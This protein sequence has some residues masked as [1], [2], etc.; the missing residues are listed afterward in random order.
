MELVPMR[1]TRKGGEE[2]SYALHPLRPGKTKDEP[3]KT[4]NNGNAL[5]VQEGKL[6]FL[7]FS[8][9]LYF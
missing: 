9:Y 5:S 1:A 3:K 6:W 8:V 7:A 4:E 2:E